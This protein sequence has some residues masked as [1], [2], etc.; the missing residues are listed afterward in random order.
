MLYAEQG[1]L[2]LNSTSQTPW[3]TN[4]HRK[5]IANKLAKSFEMNFSAANC[6]PEFQ[7]LCVLQE[8]KQLLFHSSNDD[9]YNKPF[10]LEKLT[11]AIKRSHDTAVGP[12]IYLK[13]LP[14]N[15]L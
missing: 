2:V 7:Q 15:A 12:N 3:H 6:I 10:T 4:N 5:E 1:Q 11:I 9:S 8:M 13:H 14:H